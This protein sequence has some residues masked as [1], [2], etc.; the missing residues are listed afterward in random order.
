MK[1]PSHNDCKG[2]KSRDPYVARTERNST[3][4]EDKQIPEWARGIKAEANWVVARLFI[5]N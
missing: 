4:R 2:Q 5:R 1:S 3:T